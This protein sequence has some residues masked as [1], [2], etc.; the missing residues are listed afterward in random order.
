[1]VETLRR[2]HRLAVRRGGGTQ[3]GRRLGQVTAEHLTQLVRHQCRDRHVQRRLLFAERVPAHPPHQPLDKHVG[4]GLV[5]ALPHKAHVRL[6]HDFARTQPPTHDDHGGHSGSVL[7]AANHASAASEALLFGTRHGDLRLLARVQEHV[8]AVFPADVSQFRLVFLVCLAAVHTQQHVLGSHVLQERLKAL[9]CLEDGER[10]LE[11]PVAFIFG[12]PVVA[13]ARRQ[14]L[15]VLGKRSLVLTQSRDL[16]VRRGVHRQQKGV[17]LRQ[18]SG[19]AVQKDAVLGEKQVELLLLGLDH[20]RL[21]HD[22]ECILD[23]QLGVLEVLVEDD[24]NAVL[25]LGVEGERVSHRLTLELSL[26]RATDDV[27]TR[28][29]VSGGFKHLPNEALECARLAR[30]AFG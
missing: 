16:G 29:A 7:Q 15:H 24:L 20:M 5:C 22:D 14:R 30:L 13:V 4:L 12:E 25:P 9:R 23:I 26:G 27:R 2:E 6:G 8:K 21:I 3:V 11:Q 10:R 1:L 19:V 18:H 17:L 28:D